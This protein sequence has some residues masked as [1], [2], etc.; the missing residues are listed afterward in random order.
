MLIDPDDPNPDD[1]NLT[2]LLQF[3]M[4]MCDTALNSEVYCV[5]VFS[6]PD[7]MLPVYKLSRWWAAFYIVYI[8]LEL[9]LFLNLVSSLHCF[10]VYFDTI[11][12][13]VSR[14]HLKYWEKKIPM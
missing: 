12:S 6:F 5:R 7:V 4:R 1:P 9:F 2:I 10:L 11:C 3:Y 13:L 8:S 14:N